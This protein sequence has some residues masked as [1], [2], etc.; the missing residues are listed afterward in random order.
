MTSGNGLCWNGNKF[1][2]VGRIDCNGVAGN[3]RIGPII[4][5]S[6]LSLNK[7]SYAGTNQLELISN[8][9]SNNGATNMSVSIG[10][11]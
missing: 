7:S 9:Y 4:V 2:A 5:D 6:Q 1:V 10:S 3:S 11:F 8:K